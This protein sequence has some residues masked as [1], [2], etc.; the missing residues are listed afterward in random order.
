ME[1]EFRYGIYLDSER[2]S[3]FFAKHV[4]VCEGAT[5]RALFN[6]LLDK[7]WSDLKDRQIYFLDSLGKYNIHRFMALLHRL[8]I[9]HS[10]IHDSDKNTEKHKHIN[11]MIKNNETDMTRGRYVFKDDM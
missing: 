7:E 9:P 5:E 3:L 8:G 2:S 11:E 1:E 4:V 10:I 6:C